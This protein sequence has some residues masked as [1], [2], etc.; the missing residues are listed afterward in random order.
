MSLDTLT[1]DAYQLTTL[2]A[3]ADAGRMQ[4]PVAMAFFFRKLPRNRNYVL[5]CGLRQIF[6]HAAAMRFDGGDLELLLS[7]PLI[8][9]ALKERP[10]LAAAL[11]ALDGFDGE[12]DALPEG[13][14]A[15]AGPALRSD[16]KPF[17]VGDT[18]IGIY[19]PLMQVRTDLL[20]SKLIET[21]WLGRINHL[22]MV[23]SKAARVVTAARGKPVLEFGARRTH[24]AAAVDASYAAWIAGVSATSNVAAL[25]RWGVPIAGT[26]DHF[27]VQATEQI[28]EKW[29]DSERHAFAE[30]YRVFPH[31]S[32]M[33]VDTYATEDGIRHAVA[34]TGGKLTG[35]RLDSNVTPETVAR[36]RQILDE[37]GARHAKIIVSDGL[38]E[39]RV[40]QLDGADGYG[41]GE[42]ITCSPDAAVGIGA[43]AKL[44]VNAYGKLTMKLAR[45]TGKATLPG[46]LQVH[47]F[48]D[49]DLVALA[50]EVVASNGR[51]LLQPVWR[52]RA[53]VAPPTPEQTRAYAQEEIAALP[54]ALRALET[55]APG[56]APLWPLVASDGLVAKVEQ[57]MK[58][59]FS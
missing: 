5:F 51:K 1:V 42:N 59:S 38:D 17:A 20:R 23:A 10:Q 40:A 9:P 41:V 25:R 30:F 36:A 24:P 33:L 58:E 45:G 21:P 56:A 16:G 48:A 6:E 47:R 29:P 26:M 53:P 18:R 15:F 46:E 11:R 13:T 32:I 12:I 8:G 49:H 43:V 22:S 2:V 52:G 7:D 39:F 50:D 57:L 4:S 34:A 31:N 14:P 35:V 28:G 54:P 44:T 55:P 19:T 3:H 37:L 27:Y